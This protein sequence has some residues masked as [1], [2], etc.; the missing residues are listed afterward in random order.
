MEQATSQSVKADTS[1]TIEL[2][3]ETGLLIVRNVR[4]TPWIGYDEAGDHINGNSIRHDVIIHLDNSVDTSKLDESMVNMLRAGLINEAKTLV[5]S[6]Q[7]LLKPLGPEAF[8]KTPE[9]NINDLRN[10]S[11]AHGNPLPRALKL[12]PKLET[13]DDCEQVIQAI[14]GR[15]RV[16]RESL[17][18]GN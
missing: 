15:K 16:I 13:V 7:Q 8:D 6:F 10:G 9:A 12:I 2:S 1:R 11:N 14:N 5:I 18:K 4:T 3:L 17:K